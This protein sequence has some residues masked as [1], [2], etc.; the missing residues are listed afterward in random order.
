M[1]RMQKPVLVSC[2]IMSVAEAE[3]NS[4][5]ATSWVAAAR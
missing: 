5:E 4:H 1:W 2:A 3:V